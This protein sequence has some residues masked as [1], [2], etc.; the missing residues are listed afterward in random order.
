[1]RQQ[2]KAL[3]TH[4]LHGQ[5]C[6][7]HKVLFV[8]GTKLHELHLLEHLLVGLAELLLESSLQLFGLLA[9]HLLE[10]VIHEVELL[11]VL[12]HVGTAAL[13]GASHAHHLL[14]TDLSLVLLLE[15]G[16]EHG[17]ILVGLLELLVGHV[18]D[19]QA[20]EHLAQVLGV[21]LGWELVHELRPVLLL[22]KLGAKM[23]I[24]GE[25]VW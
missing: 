14:L 9:H 25:L 6:V 1:M 18:V 16:S 13:S 7:W 5:S 2:T 11:L 23:A 8:L 10:H 19:E 4:W 3:V 12:G 22:V 20:V 15:I 21:E 24:E 17:E